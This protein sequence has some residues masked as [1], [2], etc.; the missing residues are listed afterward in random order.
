M[1]HVKNTLLGTLVVILTVYSL[2]ARAGAG[3]P[4]NLMV[5]AL[6]LAPSLL[7]TATEQ[8]AAVYLPPS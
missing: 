2:D 8:P 7:Q 5:P 6:S 1:S 3:K 4:D